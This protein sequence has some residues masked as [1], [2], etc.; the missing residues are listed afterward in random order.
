MK[1]LAH[2]KR[3]RVVNVACYNDS[4]KKTFMPVLLGTEYEVHPLF[5]RS[6]GVGRFSWSQNAAVKGFNL[7]STS[8]GS[9]YCNCITCNTLF[10]RVIIVFN[11]K[12]RKPT[13]FGYDH[14][15]T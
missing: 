5:I 12:S 1:P 15:P 3:G 6:G 7:K 13:I 2:F 4:C 8:G 10:K 9:G 14:E 11:G